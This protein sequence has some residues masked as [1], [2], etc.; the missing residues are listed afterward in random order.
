MTGRN[1]FHDFRKGGGVEPEGI[2]G[3]PSSLETSVRTP[4]EEKQGGFILR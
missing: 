1:L 2:G 4:G 3:R